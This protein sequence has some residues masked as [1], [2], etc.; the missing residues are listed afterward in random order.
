[1]IDAGVRPR[2]LPPGTRGLSNGRCYFQWFYVREG[3]LGLWLTA[4]LT[5]AVRGRYR[6]ALTGT[7]IAAYVPRLVLPPGGRGARTIEGVN[8]CDVLTL[9]VMLCQRTTGQAR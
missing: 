3:D 6:P 1:M 5:T 7:A 2:P 9:T 4:Y 8:V